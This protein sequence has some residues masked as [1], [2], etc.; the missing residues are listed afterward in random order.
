[1]IRPKATPVGTS[2]VRR[3]D[4]IRTNLLAT[5]AVVSVALFIG[6]FVGMRVF[7]KDS[8]AYQSAEHYL[9]T[10]PRI[11]QEVGKPVKIGWFFTGNFAVVGDYG[12]AFF[13]MQVSGNK[14]GKTVALL[15]KKTAGQWKTTKASYT[16]NAGEYVDLS[17][18]IVAVA[19]M[20]TPEPAEPTKRVKKRPESRLAAEAPQ[21]EITFSRIDV[22]ALR[23]Y[24]GRWIKI[25]MRDG[26]EREGKLLEVEDEALSIEQSFNFGSMT[27]NIKFHEI[28]DLLVEDS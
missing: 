23:T 7:L 28:L 1:V 18:P 15:S 5:L 21:K 4:L 14:G 16:D 8:E 6:L 26:I 20:K 11:Q 27:T 2:E 22:D 13:L 3:K 19:K 17:K 24:K 25:L 12:R 10:N 9:K